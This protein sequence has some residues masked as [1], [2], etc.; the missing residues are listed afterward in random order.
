MSAD[1]ANFILSQ[2]NHNIKI[3]EVENRFGEQD[4]ILRMI[5]K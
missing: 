1:Q 3:E 4:D 5:E 2:V